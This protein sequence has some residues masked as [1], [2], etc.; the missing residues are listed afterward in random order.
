MR[1]AAK[2]TYAGLLALLVLIGGASAQAANGGGSKAKTAPPSCKVFNSVFEWQAGQERSLKAA[3]NNCDAAP[4][5]RAWLIFQRNGN[6]A[7]YLDGEQLWDS[8]TR[9][10]GRYLV[11]R[12]Y[13]GLDIENAE[14]GTI[15]GTGAPGAQGFE[16]H[17]SGGF[18]IGFETDEEGSDNSFTHWNQGE[19]LCGPEGGCGEVLWV[20]GRGVT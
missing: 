8:D 2:L 3:D 17:P 13:G 14:H 7:F 6:L 18:G 12:G 19:G 16:P 10:E 15:W 1:S 9:G 11:E 20:S 4:G 5:R